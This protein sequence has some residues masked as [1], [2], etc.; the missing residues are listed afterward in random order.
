MMGALAVAMACS[1]ATAPPDRHRRRRGHARGLMGSL[2]GSLL[3]AGCSTA[4]TLPQMLFV[5]VSINDDEAIDPKS[6]RD[7][8]QRLALLEAGFRST[9]PGS[10]FQVQLVR[11]KQISQRLQWR[12]Q[13]GLAPDVAFVNVE[14]ALRLLELGE[15]DPYPITPAQERLFKPTTLA[16]LRDRRGRLAALPVMV[17]TQ[18]ACFN[19]R[20]LAQPPANV[21]DLLK[22]SSQGHAIGLSVDP[23]DLIWSAGSLGALAAIDRA[24]EGGQPTPAELKG[25]D[26]WL[27]WLQ[28]ANIQ[29]R[30][31]FFGNQTSALEQFAAQRIDWMICESSMLPRLSARLGATLGVS[32]LPDGPAGSASPINRLRVL[33]L[34][35]SSSARGRQMALAFSRSTI[36]PQSQHTLTLGSQS[37]LPANRFVTVPV[38][39]SARLAAMEMAA[40]QGTQNEVLAGRIHGD[41]PRLEQTRKLLNDLVF[42]E[43][44]IKTASQKLIAIL[45]RQR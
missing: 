16:R 15:T 6:V 42:G 17:R 19:R 20:R 1:R 45:R 41:D 21:D 10:H 28:T 24:A 7:F 27:N 22:L 5:N 13:A 39:S 9:H 36:S 30:I 25:L 11:E 2:M 33:V 12:T 34:G 3:L 43:L 23:V 40:R 37:V 38:Q 8:Q 35:R 32:P 44:D 4:P 14:T 31:T 18:L 26:R 29:Q